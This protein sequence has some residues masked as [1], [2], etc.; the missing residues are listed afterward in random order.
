MKSAW[1][2]LL[3]SSATARADGALTLDDALHQARVANARLPVA[4]LDVDIDRARVKEARA[5][6]WATF[7]LDGDLRY[8]PPGARYNGAQT[9][10]EERLQVV[11]LQPLYQGGGIRAGMAVADGQLSATTSRYRAV[12]KD[13]DLEVRTR[14]SELVKASNEVQLRREGVDRLRTYLSGIRSRQAAG[15]GIAADAFKT[16]VR[17]DNEEANINDTQRRIDEARLELN[18][19]M[20]RD[21]ATPLQVA[22]LPFPTPPVVAGRDDP[23]NT[24]PELQVAAAE[25]RAAVAA[26]AVTRAQ[27]RPHFDLAIDAGLWGSGLTDD[28]RGVGFVGRLRNDLGVS[29]TL[30]F[31][32]AFWDFGIYRARLRQAELGRDQA[33]ANQLVVMRH[34]RLESRRAGTDLENLFR[35]IAARARTIPAARDSYLEAESLYRG[36]AGTALEVLDSYTQWIAAQNAYQVAL[37][38]YRIAAATALRWGTP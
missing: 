20:G 12:E 27:R 2:I 36:G 11:A 4:A 24:A 5:R 38:S 31:S 3:L 6:R 29:A 16:E 17:L 14:F 7:H 10:N 19:L 33:R 23:W 25:L 8:A 28:P 18:D 37:L 1:L 32:W 21:P 15:Q 13:V 26:I 34:A 35:E 30:L 9:A 22:P